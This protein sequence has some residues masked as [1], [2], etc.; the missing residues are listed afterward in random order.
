MEGHNR[1]LRDWGQSE[2]GSP[3]LLS[4][5]VSNLLPP[6][7]LMVSPIYTTPSPLILLL[8]SRLPSGG[9]GT[10][11]AVPRRTCQTQG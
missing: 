11:A 10:P 7:Q 1:V 3:I 9:A 8:Q 5:K 4:K 6:V 2:P